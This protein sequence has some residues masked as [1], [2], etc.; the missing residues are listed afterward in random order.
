MKNYPVPAGYG[1][2]TTYLRAIGAARL[3]EFI[4]RV[5]GGTVALRLERPDGSLAHAEVL[6]GGSMIM[7]SDATPA[8]PPATATIFCYVAEVDGAHRRALDFGATEVMAPADMFHGDRQSGVQD[9][10]GNTW[11]LATRRENLSPAELQQRVTAQLQTPA[12]GSA[13]GL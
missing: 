6:V 8:W 1:A 13:A 7:V 3:I 2:V 12:A 9:Q 11:W 4:E 5:L 10:A